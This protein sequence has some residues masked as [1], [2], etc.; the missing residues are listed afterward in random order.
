MS[1]SARNMT[2]E[3]RI[4]ILSGLDCENVSYVTI[5][6]EEKIDTFSKKAKFFCNVSK[7]R[8][9]FKFV[10]FSLILYLHFTA[11]S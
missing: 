9:S 10:S 3:N 5:Q 7:T 11:E 6:H 1:V 2:E 4:P 8:D